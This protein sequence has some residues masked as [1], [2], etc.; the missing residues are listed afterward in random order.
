MDFRI[1]SYGKNNGNENLIIPS[2]TYLS[3][4]YFDWI[5]F[6]KINMD[7]NTENNV[8]VESYRDI[9]NSRFNDLDNTHTQDM[10]LLFSDCSSDDFLIGSS[11]VYFSMINLNI[12]FEKTQGQKY[13]DRRIKIKNEITKKFGKYK[14]S[15]RLY[16]TF[17]HCDLILVCDG[18][19]VSLNEYIKLLRIIR[20]IKV[21]SSNNDGDIHDITTL[22]GFNQCSRYKN[23]KMNIGNDNIT[24]TLN[25]N[26][27]NIKFID[28][29]INDITTRFNIPVPKVLELF[30]RYDNMIIWENIDSTMLNQIICM[31]QKN[32]SNFFAY[33]IYIGLNSRL[34]NDKSYKTHIDK[35]NDSLIKR[36]KKRFEVSQKF[37]NKLEKPLW[38][39][40]YEI[41]QSI[42]SMLSS[43]FAQYYVLCFYESFYSFIEHLEHKSNNNM[44]FKKIEDITNMYR[45]YFGFLN[46]LNSCMLHNERKFLQINSYQFLYFDAPPKLLAFYTAMA[47]KMALALNKEKNNNY[48]FLITPDFK[49]D[50]FVDS[51]TNDK[52]IGNE[53]NILIIHINEESIYDVSKTLRI[54]AHE[55]SHHI[56]QDEQMRKSRALLYIKCFL[57][58]I[59]SQ[60]FSNEFLIGKT[61]RAK[62]QFFCDF[63]DAFSEE[64]LTKKGWNNDA[65]D[66]LLST[67]TMYYTQNFVESFSNYVHV[68]FG[69]DEND[70]L[71]NALCSTTINKD[72]YIKE[73]GGDYWESVLK[74]CS[75]QDIS[76]KMI[77]D[78]VSKYSMQIEHKKLVEWVFEH[79]INEICD[80]VTYVFAESYADT[81]ML[82]LFSKRKDYIT[83]YTNMMV[84]P[85]GNL[86]YDD[87]IRSIAVLTFLCKN[88]KKPEVVSKFEKLKVKNSRENVSDLLKCFPLFLRDKVVEYL[89]LI[90][91]PTDDEY[92][93]FRRD[94]IKS[95]EAFESN[96]LN[97]IMHCVDKEICDYQNR[98]CTFE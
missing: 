91:T 53:H 80:I 22:Y 70:A 21:N 69:N 55:I 61:F 52:T 24:L 98:L 92:K 32:L 4:C 74:A 96:N 64:F 1:L 68:F 23:P 30:G 44:D 6:Q 2:S 66:S 11:T 97:N 41:H 89:Q 8:W 82:K 16:D 37:K 50:I 65:L 26:L 71:Y 86:E 31:T 72:S 14:D 10:M 95:I 5:S 35:I 13:A 19:R 94:I 84:R 20:Q 39:A 28:E 54:L 58:Y 38:I 47:N 73:Y 85:S 46:S 57:A 15:L 77:T 48:T 60:C 42:C 27:K 43:G 63:I 36:A 49:N 83:E 40:L 88:T 9:L 81:K 78:F 45:T 7:E 29:F 62:Y 18:D 17:D 34:T 76:K 93:I 75:E 12:H 51:L 79:D 3:G 56:G 67:K 25:L 33:H 87:E 59:V 90:N